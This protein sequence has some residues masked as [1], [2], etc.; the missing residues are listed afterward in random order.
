VL[1]IFGETPNLLLDSLLF[2][3]FSFLF[4]S[5]LL[6]KLHPV[7]LHLNK[8]GLNL[9]EFFFEFLELLKTQV[10]FRLILETLCY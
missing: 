3:L 9:L 4:I 1:V 10:H 2:L 8:T 5:F 7:L 6:A